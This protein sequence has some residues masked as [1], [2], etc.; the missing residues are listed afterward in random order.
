MGPIPW[1]DPVGS[2]WQGP[3]LSF[4]FHLIPSL[5]M[6]IIPQLSCTPWTFPRKYSSFHAYIHAVPSALSHLSF[7][8][9]SLLLI[10]KDLSPTSCSWKPFLWSFSLRLNL[11]AILHSPPNLLSLLLIA[12]VLHQN[13]HQQ[14]Q[15]SHQKHTQTRSFWISF[16]ELSWH[17]QPRL[18]RIISLSCFSQKTLKSWDVW[19]L[20]VFRVG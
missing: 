17:L 15:E 13:M 19:A 4:Q 3:S 14:P 9:F 1:L 18:L 5:G 16:I 11:L 20:W 12:S 8:L 10:H 2:S 7:C 6:N